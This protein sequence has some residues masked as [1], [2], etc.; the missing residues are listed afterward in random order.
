MVSEISG[1]INRFVYQGQITNVM[2]RA[3]PKVRQYARAFRNFAEKEWKKRQNV[4]W[5]DPN[6]P[7]AKTTK[8]RSSKLNHFF[9]V[10]AL[11]LGPKLLRLKRD[12]TMDSFAQAYNLTN[13]A[14]GTVDALI[15]KLTFPQT[16]AQVEQLL[17]DDN[18]E[19]TVTDADDDKAGEADKPL[20]DPT[21]VVPP[22]NDPP[23]TVQPDVSTGWGAKM[24]AVT[25]QIGVWNN[26]SWT[27]GNENTNAQW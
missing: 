7:A 21:T 19:S 8:F 15:G 20:T 16:R 2:E 6:G 27:N 11:N 10:T 26:K 17:D 23:A 18:D 1:V 13:I 5:L 4:I 9:T 14:V 25:T 3:G 22:T 24:A 12:V